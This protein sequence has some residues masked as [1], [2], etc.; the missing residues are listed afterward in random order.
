[1]HRLLGALARLVPSA[2]VSLLAVAVI[3]AVT[4]STTVDVTIIGGTVRVALIPAESWQVAVVAGV[5][6]IFALMLLGT[7]LHSR[8]VRR[9]RAKRGVS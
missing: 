1:M 6:A 8:Q 4:L 7:W 2:R 3:T 5:L 9:N